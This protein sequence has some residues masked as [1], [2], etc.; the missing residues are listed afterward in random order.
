MSKVNRR[1]NRAITI[2]LSDYE[3]EDIM[4]RID[5][6]GLT[7]QTYLINAARGTTITPSDEIA[8]L[9]EISK[10]FADHEKQLRGLATNINQMAHV[11]NGFG[12]LPTET[13]LERM[14]DQINNYRKE[15]ESIWQLIRSLIVRQPHTPQ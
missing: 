2:R 9:K 15:S 7:I 13:E 6:S 10:T 8:E 3:Y 11:A 1:R 4:R 12:V 5:E 14:S